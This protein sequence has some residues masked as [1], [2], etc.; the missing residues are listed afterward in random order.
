MGK[1]KKKKQK[2]DSE[3]YIRINKSINRIEELEKN[4]WRW[5]AKDRPHKNKKKYDRKKDRKIDFLS[6]EIKVLKY[7]Q[8]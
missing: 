2:I 7:I 1:S 5:V 4:G 8:C 3:E 6:E